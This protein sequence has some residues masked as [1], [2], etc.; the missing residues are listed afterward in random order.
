MIWSMRATG[1]VSV[2][3][4]S[5]LWGVVLAAILVA[6]CAAP[7]ALAQPG[8]PPGVQGLAPTRDTLFE[9][10][11]TTTPG[12]SVYVVGDTP[13]LGD[14]DVR[15]APKLS[16][17]AYPL[18]R[19]T[20]ALPAGRTITYRYLIRNDGPGQTSQSSNATTVAGPFSLTTAD[21]PRPTSTKALWLSWPRAGAILHWRTRAQPGTNPP[22][23]P[24]PMARFGPGVAGRPNDTAYLAW[25]F[26]RAGDA[27]E[28]FFT[29]AQGQNRT[30]A[31]GTYSTSLDGAWIQDGQV[32]SYVP[33]ASPQ[34]ARRNYSPGAVPTVFSPQLNESRGVRVFLPRG[35]DAHT[36]RRY[37]VLYMHDG[38]NVFES[39]AFGSWNAAST[40][41]QLQASGAIRE[42]I[43]VAL[44]NGPNRLTD[45]LPPGDFL[46]GAGRGD[47]YLQ[48]IRDTIKPQIDATYRTI[49]SDSGLMGSSMGG[50]ISLYGAWDFTS[51]FTRAGL[52]SGAW[53]TCPNF[54]A[55]VRSTPMRPVRLWLDS[56]DSGTSSD[57]YWPTL[58]LRDHFVEGT[59]PKAALN[60][61]VAHAIG[62]GQQ[63]NEAAWTI[64]LPLALAYLYPAQEE[65][66]AL[67]REVFGPHWDVTGNGAMTIDDAYA[68]ARV[69]EDLD[70]SG[71]ADPAD[72]QR[73]VGLLRREE[74][75]DLTRGRP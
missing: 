6:A 56:G 11:R 2:R 37:P 68:I 14:N 62:F 22:F 16:P 65:P 15:L 32:F 54:L 50:V 39:G 74:R 67:L 55:R 59:T 1:P 64:R 5:R 17:A 66:N 28:F 71:T 57:N 19:A 42:I 52:L 21:A 61:A 18:W 48:Y 24:R 4:A 51:T 58:S 47:R 31:L 8:T 72:A 9:I 40:I 49:P 75:R 29:D 43:V 12:Q 44:D 13:E 20:I 36:S 38:Q 73:V 53:Q 45:Y 26:G 25:G 10:S 35:Y 33:A 23:A 30:P 34:P 70:F 27:L 60:A 41:T 63:H 3:A 7:L 69:P 46:T